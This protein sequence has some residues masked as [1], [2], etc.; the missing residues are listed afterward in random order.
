M[1]DDIK[2]RLETEL[3]DLACALDAAEDTEEIERLDAAF[4]EAF[5]RLAK[6][7]LAQGRERPTAEDL[8]RLVRAYDERRGAI[9]D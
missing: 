5:L 6:H 9:Y 4:D 1:T 3:V 2:K 7:E 8:F